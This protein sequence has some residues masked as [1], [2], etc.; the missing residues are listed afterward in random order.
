MVTSCDFTQQRKIPISKHQ[1]AIRHTRKVV[2][3][4]KRQRFEAEMAAQNHRN[5][6]RAKEEGH[7]RMLEAMRKLKAEKEEREKTVDNYET[8]ISEIENNY[9]FNHEYG[10]V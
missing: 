9:K 3:E 10:E 2:E 1:A 4:Q 7:T 8:R 5:K 6:R